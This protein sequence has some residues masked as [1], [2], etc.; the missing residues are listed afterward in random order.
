MCQSQRGKYNFTMRSVITLIK[1]SFINSE[2]TTFVGPDIMQYEAWLLNTLTKN[3]YSESNQAFSSKF[4]FTLNTE[5]N[6]LS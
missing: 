2:K 5:Y 3:V 6:R 1:L 4:Y